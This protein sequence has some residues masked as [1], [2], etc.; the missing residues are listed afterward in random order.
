MSR[1]TRLL[2]L[3]LAAVQFAL[4]AVASVTDGILAGSGRND[5]AHVEDVARS[6]CKPPHAADCAICRFLSIDQAK[7]SAERIAFLS[8]ERAT[9]A[10]VLL[11][12]RIDA[13]RA[14]F[15]SRAPPTLL[16]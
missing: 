1:P 14:G 4:P 8:V 15:D 10:N 5:A 12:R 7:S 13:A 16:V 6:Q 2:T 9:A 3:A 11:S